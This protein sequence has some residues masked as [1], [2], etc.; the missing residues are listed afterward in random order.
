MATRAHFVKKARQDYYQQGLKVQARNRKGESV[1][2]YDHSQPG[3]KDDKKLVA[4]GESYW[5]WAFRFSPKQV[6]LTQPKPSQ[7]TQSEFLSNLYDLQEEISAATADDEDEIK[8]SVEEWVS[9][10]NEMADE[11]EEKHGNMPDSLQ[12]SETGQLLQDRADNLRSWA[13]ELEGVDL[14]VDEDQ[15]REDATEE[16][17]SDR[18]RDDESA[19]PTEDEINERFEEKKQERLNEILEEVQNADYSGE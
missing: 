3:S 18:L 4:K 14:E 1:T 5:W 13:D 19:E 10:I 8:A 15:L 12:D 6:S 16:L 11:C 9:R 7:L 17:K 2:R